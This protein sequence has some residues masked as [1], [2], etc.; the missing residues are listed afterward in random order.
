MRVPW[1]QWHGKAQGQA[2]WRLGAS[3]DPSPSCFSWLGAGGTVVGWDRAF[4]TIQHCA[5][6][7]P[8]QRYPSP[9]L[10]GCLSAWILG[11]LDAWMSGYLLACLGCLT[12]LAVCILSLSWGPPVVVIRAWWPIAEAALIKL[13]SLSLARI[14]LGVARLMSS[15]VILSRPFAIALPLYESLPRSDTPRSS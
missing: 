9:R 2:H 14:E 6:R 13:L 5:H 15:H 10:E 3:W 8:Q 1:G 7:Q 11:S 12:C 4:R